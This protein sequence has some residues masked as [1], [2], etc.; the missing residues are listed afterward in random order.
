MDRTA[1]TVP[2]CLYK[3][4]LYLYLYSRSGNWT[5]SPG[6]FC[7]P[8]GDLHYP[9]FHSHQQVGYYPLLDRTALEPGRQFLTAF[10][11]T[12]FTINRHSTMILKYSSSIQERTKKDLRMNTDTQTNHSYH[13][14]WSMLKRTKLDLEPRLL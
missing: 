2:Q 5:Y 4:A 12:S 6:F 10:T 13:V 8:V 7:A 14:Q 9:P 11:L 1:C 3:G